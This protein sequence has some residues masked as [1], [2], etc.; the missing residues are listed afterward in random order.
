MR[1]GTGQ[2]EML[3]SA[4]T[5]PIEAD[6]TASPQRESKGMEGTP[7]PRE[8]FENFVLRSELIQARG[9]FIRATA[10]Y[11]KRMGRLLLPAGQ[12]PGHTPA[13]GAQPRGLYRAGQGAWLSRSSR[14]VYVPSC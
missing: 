10:Q 13:V 5:W 6:T 2:R 1:A 14:L 3:K 9:L 11:P 7:H 4:V 8:A 12:G